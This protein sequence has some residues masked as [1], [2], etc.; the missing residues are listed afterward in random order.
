[1]QILELT[2]QTNNIIET[3][4]FYCQTIGLEKAYQTEESISFFL[5]TSKLI[6]ESI[7][8]ETS[9]KYHFAFNIPINKMEE[10][11]NWTSRRIGLI[12]LAD[13]SFVT[14]FENWK[15]EAIYFFDNN[16]NILEFICRSDL[17]NFVYSMFSNDTILNIN[18]IGIVTDKPLEIAKEIIEK[19]N[20]TFFSK[21]PTREDFVAVGTDNG[22]FAISSQKE[23]GIQHKKKQK[24]K[25]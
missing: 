14:H 5:G 16:Q 7:E 4:K 10:A 18:E 21:G 12:P 8:S 1:M 15:A 9:P 23:I 6:F 2:L 3:E 25:P 11:I 17:N 22:L 20:T 13:N 24:N 19:T